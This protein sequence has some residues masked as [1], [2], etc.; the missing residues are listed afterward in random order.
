VASIDYDVGDVVVCLYD[1]W[2]RA[3]NTNQPP[4]GNAPKM[5][6]MYRV[7]GIHDSRIRPG[8][9]MARFEGIK[10]GYRAQY[11]RKVPKAKDWKEVWE[12]HKAPDKELVPS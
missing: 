2:G 5:G 1:E 11:F 4:P 7:R 8:T 9:L 10:G 12:S 6:Q 3:W